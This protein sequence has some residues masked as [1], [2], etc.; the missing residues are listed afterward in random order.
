[1]SGLLPPVIATLIA[2][3]KEYSAKMT[4]AQAQ[5]AE[6]GKTSKTTSE[7]LKDFGSKASTAIVGVGLA[8]GTYA[9]DQA[10]KFQ[11]SLDKIKNQAGL[12][13]EQTDALGKSIQNIANT[14]GVANS[15]LFDAALL[16]EQAGLRGADASKLL[17]S[18]AKASII[19]NS[20]VVDITKA[21]IATQT[22]QISKGMDVAKLTGILVKGSY[23]FVGGLQAE[24][25]M[26]SGKVAVALAKYGFQLKDVIPLGAEFA[27]I[28]LPTR[29]TVAFANSLA[30][31]TKPM[32]DAKG[33]Y[34]TY[35]KSLRQVGLDQ[36]K[37]ASYMRTGDIAG[38]LGSI[39]SAAGGNATKEGVLTQAVFGSAGSGAALAVLKDWNAYL[40]ES[41]NLT[42]AGAGTLQSGFAEALKQIGPQLNLVKTN[43]NNLMI[44]AGKLLLP[45]VAKV[46][47]WVS[48]FASE[49]N[50]NKALRETLGIGAGTLFAGAVATKLVKAFQSIMGLFGKGAQVAATNANTLALEANTIALGGKA[51][52]VGAAA[53]G[54]GLVRNAAKLVPIVAVNVAAYEL[55][56]YAG[57]TGPTYAQSSAQ[58]KLQFRSPMPMGK[59]TVNLT[60]HSRQSGSKR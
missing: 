19:T 35:A 16:A 20:S 7:K 56:K 54:G 18:A 45:S 40:A 2:D 5:M 15:Q 44:N 39:R 31:L 4:E 14:T 27:K 55:L 43:F 48:S 36:Q 17:D 49:V 32:T 57:S 58:G 3:T 8:L 13:T 47:S 51:A 33:H 42:G 1:M 24:E 23:A 25:A 10:Y 50:K 6:F 46:A 11:E 26:L 41:K 52:G 59:T 38:L 29:S 60:L 22:L 28:G 53:A 12:T 30:N 37:L 21:L 34:T 9:V